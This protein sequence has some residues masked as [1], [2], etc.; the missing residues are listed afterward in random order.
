M[1]LTAAAS[2]ISTRR[3]IAAGTALAAAAGAAW[4]LGDRAV[5]EA[6]RVL[7][8]AGRLVVGEFL[9]RHWIPFGRLHQA[10]AASGLHFDSRR[11]TT[12]A[13][14]ARFRQRAASSPLFAISG[15]AL[16]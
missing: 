1:G 2:R 9:D 10:A 12:L 11:G 4:W 13:Y 5:R 14:L 7:S 6:A 3:V 15:N 8:P 16:R